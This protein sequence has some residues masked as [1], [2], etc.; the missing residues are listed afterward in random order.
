MSMHEEKEKENGKGEK[1]ATKINP[2]AWCHFVHGP[3]LMTH[4]EFKAG[5]KA[6]CRYSVP[7]AMHF[8]T[9]HLNIVNQYSYFI[10][11]SSDEFR[12]DL[13][14]GLHVQLYHACFLDKLKI[15]LGLT[16]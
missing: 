4:S 6:E 16:K 10:K 5:K 1:E 12:F 3:T 11:V 9:H 7:Q 15:P 13:V 2:G 8:L 14:L